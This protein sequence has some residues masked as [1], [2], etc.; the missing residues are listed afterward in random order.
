MNT[1]EKEILKQFEQE[2]I[3]QNL[4][5]YELCYQI[6]LEF[7]VQQTEFDEESAYKKLDLMHL[8]IE[9]ENVFYTVVAIIRGEKEFVKSQKEFE[10]KLEQHAY[11]N[12]LEDYLRSDTQLIHPE[13]FLEQTIETINE[14]HFFTQKMQHIFNEEYENVILRWK[15]IITKE[16]AK[17]IQ[18]TALS[19]F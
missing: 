4:A 2:H 5:R 17:K 9:P 12:A 15:L 6:A 10:K 19:M 8:E 14:N 18:E 16:L 3:I 7:L 11:I 13:M 1:T